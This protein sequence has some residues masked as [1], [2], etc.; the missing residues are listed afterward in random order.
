MANKIRRLCIGAEVKTQHIYFVGGEQ[1]VFVD[2]KETKM[3]IHSIDE[4]EKHYL[5]NTKINNEVQTWKKIPKNSITTE[6]FF[7]D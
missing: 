1:R 7:I 6:E 3:I 2:G 5:I 4:T